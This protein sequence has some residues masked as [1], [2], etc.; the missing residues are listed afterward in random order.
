MVQ[1]SLARK[2]NQFDLKKETDIAKWKENVNVAIVQYSVK[3]D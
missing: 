3:N 2:I 1:T